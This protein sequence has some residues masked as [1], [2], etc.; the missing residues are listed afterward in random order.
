MDG[1]VDWFQAV[2]AYCERT[3]PEYWSEPLNAITNAAFLLAAVW[4]WPQ[5]RGYPA[6]RA[7]AV[8]LG[9]I[10]IGSWMF[11]TQATRIA[12]LEDVLPIA[13]FILTY[14]FASSRDLLGL[15]T[16]WAVATA[17]AFLPYAAATVPVWS[18]LPGLGSSAGYM[19]VPVLILVYAGLLLISIAF[20]SADGPFCAA[21]PVGT[22]FIWHLLNAVMLAHMIR[23]LVRGRLALRPHA[24]DE[25][26]AGGSSA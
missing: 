14:V 11:H 13:A 2:D 15:R 12:E 22:H 21:L 20:R 3:G 18:L 25:G 17:V 1:R 23:V 5:T 9:V 4:V 19:P 8:N 7:L 16:G 26:G 10:G 6:A 24:G